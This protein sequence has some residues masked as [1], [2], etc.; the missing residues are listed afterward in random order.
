[1]PPVPKKYRG[2][3]GGVYYFKGRRPDGTRRKVYV[4]QLPESRFESLPDEVLIPILMRMSPRELSQV[5]QTSRRMQLLCQDRYIRRVFDDPPKAKQLVTQL[6]TWMF[7][8]HRTPSALWLSK[9]R[10]LEGLSPPAIVQALKSLPGGKRKFL[11]HHSP[12][13]QRIWSTVQ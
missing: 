3:R 11:L 6:T 9:L 7:A 13:L 12:K 1:M 4:H 10:E 8:R 5:C 2:P